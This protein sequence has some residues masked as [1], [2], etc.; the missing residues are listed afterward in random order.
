MTRVNIINTSWKT[1]QQL[2]VDKRA[3]VIAL[4]GARLSL[5]DIRFTNEPGKSDRPNHHC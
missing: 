1:K 4:H 5:E 3:A 2:S